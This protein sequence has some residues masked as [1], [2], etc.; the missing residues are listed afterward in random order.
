MDSKGYVN[1]DYV[2]KQVLL[3]LDDNTLHR[4]DKYLQLAINGFT[5][6]NLFTIQN[7]RVAY[8][9]IS[10]IKTVDLPDDYIMYTKIGYNR[11][12]S[13]YNLSVNDNLMLARD[14]GDCGEP[15]NDNQ[16]TCDNTLSYP[17][18][19]A[20]YAPHWRNGN[21]V[22]EVYGASGGRADIQFRIDLER[23]Q[24]VLDSDVTTGDLAVTELIL[25]Y[26]SSGISIAGETIVPREYVE[27]LK[28]YI[29]WQIVEYKDGMAMNIK[30]R[31][32]NLYYI[33]YEKVRKLVFSFTLQD[34]LDM[35][36]ST[37][38]QTP[39]R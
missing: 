39:K 12:G 34:Y 31:S 28:K 11:D 20:Y 3:D 4:Y 26:K 8:L 18:V 17:Y 33:E 36:Y 6:L 35:T 37:Y 32:Q 5:A 14:N 30:Q 22:G 16:A 13:F 23:R 24:I 1:L 38:K 7:V 29:H 10:N 27:C 15:V 9:P 19:G 21:F 25:E 2:V